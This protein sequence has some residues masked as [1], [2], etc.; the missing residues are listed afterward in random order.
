MSVD[1][2]VFNYIKTVHF[3]YSGVLTEA[4]AAR[5]VEV[6]SGC[7]PRSSSTILGSSL[8]LCPLRHCEWMITPCNVHGTA[9][10]VISATG[11]W[12]G[13]W[14]SAQDEFHSAVTTAST[15]YCPRPSCSLEQQESICDY[16]GQQIVTS[17]QLATSLLF[18]L[19]WQD[20]FTLKKFGYRKISKQSFRLF[21]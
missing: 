2:V 3:A 15:L 7:I 8:K 16:L 4:A 13:A 9:W 12:A 10:E 6:V 11:V 5:L 1:R 21:Q 19:A 20:C 17:Q 18:L 14:N